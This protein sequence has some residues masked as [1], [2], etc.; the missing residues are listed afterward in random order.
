MP[1]ARRWD[2]TARSTRYSCPP[3]ARLASGGT[4]AGSMSAMSIWRPMRPGP[5]CPPRP[6]WCPAAG[7]AD[8][9]LLRTARPPHARPGGDRRAAAPSS[10]GLPT[11]GRPYAGR[12]IGPGGRGDQRGRGRAGLSRLRRT[13]PGDRGASRGPRAG[14]APVLCRG[15]VRLA[16][17]PARSARAYL[18]INLARAADLVADTIRSTAKV[19]QAVHSSG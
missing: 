12:V 14:P 18:G 19:S 1:R 5:G 15:C 13:R 7:A 4:P 6:E 2:S 10:L 17:G 16:P 3:C 8:H 9:P 11:A